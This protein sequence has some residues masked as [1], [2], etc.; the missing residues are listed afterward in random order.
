[1]QEEMSMPDPSSLSEIDLTPIPDK[2][3]FMLE[4]E[5]REEFVYFL[6]TDRFH[7]DQRRAP[8]LGPDRQLLTLGGLASKKELQSMPVTTIKYTA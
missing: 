5:W 4:R 8:S 3:Y 2:K 7:D 6:M 1:M